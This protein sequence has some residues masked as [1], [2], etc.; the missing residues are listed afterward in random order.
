M[1][2]DFES[3]AQHSVHLTAGTRHVLGSFP[4]SSPVPAKQRFLVPS[5]RR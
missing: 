1:S 2:D 3:A 4:G 5:A